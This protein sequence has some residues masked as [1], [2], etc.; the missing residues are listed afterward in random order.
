MPDVFPELPKVS[1][2]FSLDVATVYAIE[3]AL[4]AHKIEM[5]TEKQ[6]FS[7]ELLEE[8]R[9][10]LS[11]PNLFWHL[12]A[13]MCGRGNFN[14]KVK[15]LGEHIILPLLQKSMK[16]YEDH[17]KAILPSL[18][19]NVSPLIKAWKIHGRE[20]LKGIRS[21][22]R[23]EWNIK[24]IK[25]FFVEPIASENGSAVGDAFP[26]EGSITFE[27]AKAPLPRCLH[28]L[29]HEIAHLNTAD[30]IHQEDI[31]RKV[32]TECANDLVAQQALIEAKMLNKLDFDDPIRDIEMWKTESRQEFLYD[33]EELKQIM[34][35]WW[36]NHLES[37]KNLRE[38]I[39]DLFEEAL[40]RMPLK[41]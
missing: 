38:S 12:R 28:G 24:E 32:L 4:H 26:E 2:K 35:N 3:M 21:A 29:T 19:N 17:W 5:R 25:V 23:L 27:A 10:A 22:S 16:I 33:P 18:K 37:R 39:K 11:L 31:R 7:E 9:E 41:Q 20:I 34:E 36:S 8:W 1:F 14:V 40:P 13:F 15:R 30:I 6:Y